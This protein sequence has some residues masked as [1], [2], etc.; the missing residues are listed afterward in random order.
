MLHI[1]EKH[2]WRSVVCIMQQIINNEC[3]V[4][5]AE[6]S[7]G[8]PRQLNPIGGDIDVLREFSGRELRSIRHSGMP[9]RACKALLSRGCVL[10][11]WALWLL[12]PIPVWLDQRTL[13]STGVLLFM[14]L[15]DLTQVV[16]R[17]SSLRR[18][19]EL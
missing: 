2:W 5:Y 12:N 14:S 8:S 1:Q 11:Q 13:S 10:A 4:E 3:T 17:L 15:L 6:F 19:L 9:S 16:E 7:L 18:R